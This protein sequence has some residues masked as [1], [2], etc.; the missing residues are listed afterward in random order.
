MGADENDPQYGWRWVWK[1]KGPDHWFMS[2]IYA[3]VG[4]D[5]FSQAMA[6]VVEPETF[7]GYAQLAAFSITAL[8]CQQHGT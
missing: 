6:Q 3:Q 4:I 1:R 5:R 7:G 2:M 8:I